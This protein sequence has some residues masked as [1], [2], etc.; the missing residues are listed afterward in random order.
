MKKRVLPPCWGNWH[1]RSAVMVSHAANSYDIPG[2]WEKQTL[3]APRAYAPVE[4]EGLGEGYQGD[5]MASAWDGQTTVP[6]GGHLWPIYSTYCCCSNLW[7]VYGGQMCVVCLMVTRKKNGKCVCVCAF[8]CVCVGFSVCWGRRGCVCVCGGGGSSLCVCM[9]VCGG[10][11][12]GRVGLAKEDRD[13]E[14]KYRDR[15][16]QPTKTTS[17]PLPLGSS[18]PPPTLPSS[19]AAAGLLTPS[20]FKVTA[21]AVRA[22]LTGCYAQTYITPL[23]LLGAA[24]AVPTSTIATGVIF[25]ELSGDRALSK[26][27]Q[28][29]KKRIT[30]I[31]HRLFTDSSL[32]SSDSGGFGM[33]VFLGGGRF[34][35]K[36]GKW[37]SKKRKVKKKA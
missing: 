30:A 23:P 36:S 6:C 10:W 28:K 12:G 14:C 3:R 22:R 33:S 21:A 25:R 7:W 17:L 16:K 18:Q 8:H 29:R 31:R 20:E 11:G 24:R 26:F 35:Q 1:S 9:C 19:S 5:E 32:N 37:F 4:W 15:S 13:E 2:V 27:D 34:F